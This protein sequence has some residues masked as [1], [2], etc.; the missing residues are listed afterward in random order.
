VTKELV[1]AVDEVNDH[2]WVNVRSRGGVIKVVD[3]LAQLERS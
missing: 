2:F 1:S 3:W